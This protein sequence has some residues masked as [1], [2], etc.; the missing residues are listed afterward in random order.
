MK[1]GD[2]CYYIIEASLSNKTNVNN[3]KIL[4]NY[5]KYSWSFVNMT[6]GLI[7]GNFDTSA[8]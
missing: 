2:S 7:P 3:S 8:N 1:Q 4:V 5:I 6:T